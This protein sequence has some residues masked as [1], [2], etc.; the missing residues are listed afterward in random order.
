M[1]EETY[2]IK[3]LHWSAT[4]YSFLVNETGGWVSDCE[5]FYEFSSIEDFNKMKEYLAQWE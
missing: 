1:S 2:R 3:L 4:D 5:K